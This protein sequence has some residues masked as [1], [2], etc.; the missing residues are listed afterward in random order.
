MVINPRRCA[1][2]NLGGTPKVVPGQCA[3]PCRSHFG[4]DSHQWSH[5]STD[6]PPGGAKGD[7]LDLS[8]TYAVVGRF[9]TWLEL[10]LQRH[11]QVLHRRGAPMQCGE[12]HIRVF[13]AKGQIS[14]RCLVIGW[15][16]PKWFIFFFDVMFCNMSCVCVM[17][18]FKVFAYI[19]IC[20]IMYWDWSFN[21]DVLQNLTSTSFADLYTQ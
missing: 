15:L 13:G 4:C 11:V 18:S 12:K 20:F 17:A 10:W 19:S 2:R 5:G 9:T 8:G 16:I 1:S 21:H 7:F 3:T 14:V 6:A